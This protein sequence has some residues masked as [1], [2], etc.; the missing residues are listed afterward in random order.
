[1]EAD[2]NFVNKVISGMRMI[3]EV[4]KTEVIS[5]DQYV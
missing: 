4:E 5:P 2:N 1:M 3:R